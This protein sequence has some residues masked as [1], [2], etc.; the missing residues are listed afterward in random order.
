MEAAS[1]EGVGIVVVAF[2]FTLALNEA[3]AFIVAFTFTVVVD[4]SFILLITHP[5]VPS[6][7]VHQCHYKH[8]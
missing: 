3:F 6:H 7:L 8:C 1:F 4:S 5:F 2:A